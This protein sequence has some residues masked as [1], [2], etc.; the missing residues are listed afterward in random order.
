MISWPYD[1]WCEADA[2]LTTQYRWLCDAFEDARR[3]DDIGRNVYLWKA[4]SDV[5][6]QAQ[7]HA[8]LPI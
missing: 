1:R 2:V 3:K 5:C 6:D 8:A 7:A 4:D